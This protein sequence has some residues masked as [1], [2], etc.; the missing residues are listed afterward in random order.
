MSEDTEKTE[1]SETKKPRV[2]AKY[3]AVVGL[4]Y[5]DV[6]VEAGDVVDD[7]PEDSLDWLLEGNYIVKVK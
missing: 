2:K 7:I 5:G 4:N 3:R 1:V 6:R